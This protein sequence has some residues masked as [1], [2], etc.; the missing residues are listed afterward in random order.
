MLLHIYH[1]FSVSSALRSS[2]C[3]L[4]A[5]AHK[6][7]RHVSGYWVT[8]MSAGVKRRGEVAITH[9]H[10]NPVQAQV[11]LRRSRGFFQVASGDWCFGDVG[12]TRDA[13]YVTRNA[14]TRLTAQ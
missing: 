1:P 7:L 5:I 6:Y 11:D 10:L 4:L 13:M 9:I 8:V 14:S 12:S 2:K 3:L